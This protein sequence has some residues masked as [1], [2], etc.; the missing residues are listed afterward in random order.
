M[1]FSRYYLIRAKPTLADCPAIDHDFAKMLVSETVIFTSDEG[2]RSAFTAEDHL[3]KVKLLFLMNLKA[4][5][6]EGHVD[7]IPLSVQFFDQ[8]WTTEII[9][10]WVAQQEVLDGA[11][12]DLIDRVLPT[13]RPLVDA[14]FKRLPGTSDPA[15]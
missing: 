4:S 10:E 2:G 7:S 3:A 14:W 15:P 9:K 11:A 6:D 8:W 5:Y 1:M 12:R 13:G